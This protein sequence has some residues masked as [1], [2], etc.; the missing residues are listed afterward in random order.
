MPAEME[1]CLL[2]P[3]AVRHA[4]T[5]L[6]VTAARQRAVLAALL[7]SAGRTV[8]PDELAEALW[9]SA[10][11]RTARVSIQNYVMR[12]RRA[13]G[14]A[15]PARIRTLPGGYAIS[16]A[17]GELDVS[18]FETLAESARTAAQ[19]RSWPDAAERAGA[20]LALWQ[21]EPLADAGSELLASRHQPR[22]TE[23]WLA[24]AET[25][26]EARLHLGRAA[27]AIAE[28]R[29]LAAEHPLRERLHGLLMAALQ[30]DGRSGEALAAYQQARRVLV[31]ELGAEPGP[32][33]RELHRRILAGDRALA[34]GPPPAA[35]GQT[36]RQPGQS[37]A[38]APAHRA[39]HGTAV[40]RQ[41]PAGARHFTGRA[42]ELAALTRLLDQAGQDAP[43]TVLIS[44]IG[45]MAG[46]GKTTLA[47]HWAHR[48]AGRFPDGQL[49]VNL[50]GYDARQPVPPADALAG[51]LRA[52]GLT[53]SDI[54]ADAEERAASY[55]SLLAGR[56]VLV[57]LDN[58]GSEEQVRPL[59]PGSSASVLVT[60]RDPLPGLVARDGATRLDLDLLPPA[61]AAGL[62]TT[63]IGERAEADPATVTVLAGLCGRLPL[64]LRVA[65]ELAA[66]R[67]DATLA[68]LASELA[69][70][71]RRLDLLDAGGDPGT[72]IRS[73][74]SWSCRHLDDTAVRA[75]RLAG[76][77]PAADFDGYA[78]AALAGTTLTQ[79]R[80][81]LDRLARA[82]LVQL[83]Q[84][85]QPGRYA[86]H[87]L[88][89]AYAREL[90]EAR[91]GEEARRAALTRLLDHYLHTAAAA[92]DTLRPWD[93]EQRPRVPPPDLPGPPVAQPAAAQAW[94]DAERA[95]LVAVTG[96][97]A[98]HGWPSYAIRL[99]A[100]LHRYLEYGGHYAEALTV[101]SRA[102]AAASSTGDRAAEAAALTAL[103]AVAWRQDHYRRAGTL[104]RRA[105]TLF[106]QAG[107]RHGEAR[108][109]QTLGLVATVEGR[110]P[111]ADRHYR[112]ALARYRE[113]GDRHGEA[114]V[115]RNLAIVDY[116][117]G[118]YQQASD[119]LRQALALCR[120]T[121]D[122]AG[123]AAALDGL[124]SVELRLGH[125][126]QAARYLQDA[127][128]LCRQTGNRI[129][130]AEALSDLGDLRL[131]QGRYEQAASCHRQAMAL[132]QESGDRANEAAA[133][134]GLGEVLLATGQPGPAHVQLTAA[135]GLL[136][137]IGDK[138]DQ[139]RTHR[140]LGHA[141]LA[142]GDPAQARRHWQQAL[143][144]Y[145]SLGTPEAGQV[146][147][148]LRD[149]AAG[150]VT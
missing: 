4:G 115:L 73:V 17:D 68:G 98:E 11:P 48:V 87:D 35:A 49:Y 40:P 131:R 129:G 46:V 51:F 19:Q 106:H 77:H 85:G 25:R 97:A 105:L 136:S 71:R 15:G 125:Y 20:A 127:L 10:P 13:L 38:L 16:V 12:L 18:R 112:Q 120:G 140:N 76:L 72:A 145:T 56:Q 147:A 5:T 102:R 90:S 70:Q 47:V 117:Q 83:A 9:G 14:E 95:C 89:R 82:Y 57:V 58:A 113:S 134:N 42:G 24:A 91:D 6:P 133:L 122:T 108:V 130:E 148:S 65:A 143:D 121:A 119:H 137:Q 93:R 103:G 54:P 21:G 41:L 86:M 44:A 123:L 81:M 80:Q 23:L 43:G 84:P 31:A 30:Q 52:L 126:Q 75:F 88:L 150:T 144:L 74:L 132:Y 63:L 101:H 135:L 141:C 100:V 79:A 118:R 94:L 116:D 60:S 26:A 124:G 110:Y 128:T 62:L 139:A 33:L 50:R 34:A 138:H 3:L 27:A 37:P 142:A 66:A 96:H 22:L 104:L 92:M 7:L 59:L 114:A 28:L 29:Q 146:R 36:A 32:E 111:R 53:A 45:G 109:L 149:L 2:G 67:R 78:V 55:R 39:D 99:G 61:D 1:F 64:A 8:G 69:D 107:D